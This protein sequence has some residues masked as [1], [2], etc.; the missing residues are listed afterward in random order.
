LI[1][2]GLNLVDLDMF[3]LLRKFD[4]LNQTMGDKLLAVKDAVQKKQAHTR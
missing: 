2:Q 1:T 4:S 3:R